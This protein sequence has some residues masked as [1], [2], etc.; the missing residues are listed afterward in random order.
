[1]LEAGRVDAEQRQ[2]RVFNRKVRGLELTARSHTDNEMVSGRVSVVVRQNVWC[3]V[4]PDTGIGELQ[5]HEIVKQ[6]QVSGGIERLTR[7]DFRAHFQRLAL[8]N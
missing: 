8:L 3:G 2:L 7:S 5:R 4:S 1:M 6:R